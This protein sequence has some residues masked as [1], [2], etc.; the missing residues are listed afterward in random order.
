MGGLC[1]ARGWQPRKRWRL[2]CNLYIRND[3]VMSY[4]SNYKLWVHLDQNHVYLD[5]VWL[6]RSCMTVAAEPVL[7]VYFLVQLKWVLP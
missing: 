2:T 3:E 6:C 4:D 7:V 1:R 5:S